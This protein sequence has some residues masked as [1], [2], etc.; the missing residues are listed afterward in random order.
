[1]SNLAPKLIYQAQTERAP[2]RRRTIFLLFAMTAIM[3]IYR[4]FVYIETQKIDNPNLADF[5][6]E[7]H[8]LITIG[9]IIALL[10]F[11]ALIIRLIFSLRA[12]ITLRNE[13]VR[14]FNQGFTWE[15]DGVLD[16]YSWD[17][18]RRYR[19]GA[20]V[21]ALFN[22]PMI[23]L[24]ENSLLMNDKRIYKFTGRLGDPRQFDR[25]VSP[26]I[27]DITGQRMGT[28]LREGKSIKL[29][30]RLMVTQSGIVAG[31]HK[32]A[33]DVADIE[34]RGEKLILRRV[35]EGGKFKTVTTI[36]ARYIDNLAGFMDVAESIIQNYQPHRFNIR[37]K[38]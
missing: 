31:K 27:A 34:L 11:I 29:G 30:S 38:I 12:W 2:H 33:W 20:R 35:Q 3:V 13:R 14:V 22:R 36:P 16:K 7:N 10:V 1:M 17:K 9:Q 26:I 6:T 15:R 5:L 8:T 32:L 37:T 23:K 21:W 28:A 4:I 25:A 24:G 19:R 18:V